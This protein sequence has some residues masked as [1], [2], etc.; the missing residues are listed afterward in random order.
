MASPEITIR[1]A[2]PEDE[3]EVTALFRDC[4]PVL[5]AEAYRPQVLE[6]ALPLMARANP[7]LLASGRFYLAHESGGAAI[8]CG[9]W[10]FER[11][12]TGELVPGFGHIRHFA[13]HTG[14]TGKGVARAVYG[15]CEA[16]A[17]AAG[18]AAFE[19]YSSLNAEGF[20][21]AMGFERIKPFDIPMT[22]EVVLPSILM[23]KTFEA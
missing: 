13:T 10:S 17:R 21:A 7:A 23:R 14:W 3:P 12:G 22:P 19:C 1:V 6:A 20:Y 15:Q 2:V 11:P 9:G 16:A 4:Y 8:G 18:L 5:M